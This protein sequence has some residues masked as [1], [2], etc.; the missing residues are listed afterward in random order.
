M[1]LHERTLEPTM[2]VSPEI[3]FWSLPEND[4]WLLHTLLDREVPKHNLGRSVWEPGSQLSIIW[5]VT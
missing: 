3:I 1:F 5:W 2:V 4:F